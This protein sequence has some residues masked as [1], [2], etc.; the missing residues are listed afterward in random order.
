MHKD[1]H[2]ATL[3]AMAVGERQ[4]YET[5]LDRYAHDMRTRNTCR[6]RRPK[7]LKG[8][9]FTAT[10]FTAVAAGSAGDVRYVICLERV[11]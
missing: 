1:S 7:L 8:R 6:S 9:E 10:L 4:Y 3:A 5:T 2:N 11:K